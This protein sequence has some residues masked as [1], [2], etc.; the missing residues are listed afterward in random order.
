MSAAST[1]VEPEAED[2]S[3]GTVRQFVTFHV[4]RETF[5]VPLAEVQEIIRLPEMVEVPLAPRSL[6]GLANLRGNVL[7]VSSLRRVFNL[8]DTEHDDATR[9]VVIN[10]GTPVGFVVDRMAS[11]VTSEMQEIESTDT[12]H[13]T[14]A[15]DLVS[16]MIK[17]A[18]GMI[19]ILEPSRLMRQGSRG[20]RKETAVGGQVE[21]LATE[22]SRA[23]EV[24]ADEIQLVSF[25]LAGQEYALP[26]EHVQEIVQVPEVISAVPNCDASVLGV[27][28]LRNRLLPLVSLRQL[29][30]LPMSELSEQCR[31]VVVSLSK[32]N[33]AL[34]V[35][36]VTDTVKEV[37]RVP[38]SI[39]DPLPELLSNGG[40]L[41]EVEMI[42]RIEDGKRLVS[43]LSTERLF[44][45]V[46]IQ[47]V[48][49]TGEL[50]EESE[51]MTKTGDDART[52]I[53]EE[54]QFVVFRL[55]EEEYG[56]PIDTV[57]EIVRVPEQLTHVPKAASFIEGMV[58]LRGAVLP[59]IDQR[60]RF[61]LPSIERNDRQ[62]I[63]VFTIGGVRTGFIVDNVSEVLRIPR[64]A[65][66]PA[67]DI[68][69]DESGAITHV[70]NMPAA[71]RMILMLD[72]AKLLGTEEMEA[73]KHAA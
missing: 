15:T 65:I 39:V 8:P 31:I 71:K 7:P 73:V 12:M 24:A 32:D 43:I 30:G 38:R 2:Q 48:I 55:A 25:G 34:A 60:K 1:V 11:V 59:V 58:N 57:Q 44:T 16:G 5:A 28:T 64:A 23:N 51:A 14:V 54:D 35:G 13:G 69:S 18:S 29:F 40:S 41:R 49:K 20:A 37:L 66:A 52:S 19:M 61:G 56:I 68:A 21:R 9:V 10:H 42:C 17:R 46:T 26:I 45:N 36:I 63:M 33:D 70:A 27:M 3:S 53:E 50:R 47:E 67:P 72:V 6:A 62:R 4:D 22:R